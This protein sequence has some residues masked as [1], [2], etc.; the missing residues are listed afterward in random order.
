MA[1]PIPS[2]KRRP[3]ARPLALAQRAEPML[4]LRQVDQ[5]EV[6]GEGASDGQQLGGGTA[7]ERMECAFD[8]LF[9]A[10]A[11]AA[12][13]RAA[14]LLDELEE[15][16]TL[17]LDDDLA[18]QGAEE[19]DLAGKGISCAGAADTSWLGASGGIA[20]VPCPG[21]GR[22]AAISRLLRRSLRARNAP[23]RR[24]R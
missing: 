19:L 15:L 4:L 14:Q 10:G 1:A 23:A 24:N 13:G 21:H 8:R 6:G 11:T 20:R 7:V 12:D 5:Q 16:G 22:D 2:A 9:G 18:E 17:L 3:P